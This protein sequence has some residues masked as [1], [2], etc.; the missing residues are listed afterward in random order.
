M[1]VASARCDGRNHRWPM[2]AYEQTT[3]EAEAPADREV[4]F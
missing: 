2:T 1:V 3:T 4:L